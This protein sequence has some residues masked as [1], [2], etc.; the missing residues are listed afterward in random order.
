MSEIRFDGRVAIVTGAG[1][2]IGRGYAELLAARGARVIVND[3]GGAMA[4]GGGDEGPA[5]QAVDAITA[6]GGSAEPDPSDIST[7]AGAQLVVDHALAS[8]GRLDI[9]VNNAGI[10]AMDAFPDMEL[11]DLQRQLTVHV[12]GS[13]NVTRAA[14]PHLVEAG[15]GRVV[16]TTSTG[17]LGSANLSAYGPAKAG[18]LGLGRALAMVGEG[19]GIKVNIVAPLAMTRMMGAGLRAV[20]EEPPDDPQRDPA[21]VAPLVAYLCH[22]DCQAN[23]ETFLSCLRRYARIFI[24]ENEGYV[25]P[26]LDVTIEAIAANWDAITTDA[27]PHVVPDTMSQ[28]AANAERIEGLVARGRG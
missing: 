24:V 26:D 1:R 13:F 9:V 23:G 17:A 20:G 3:L 21:L 8:Y 11:A 16:M 12:G 4:G 7:A 6:A 10:Y 22:E 18:V 2:G 28:S 14:W 27:D 15:Y 19:L 25:H 5:R